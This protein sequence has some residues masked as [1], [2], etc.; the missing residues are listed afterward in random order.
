METE[1]I[2]HSDRAARR[3]GEEEEEEERG[4]EQGTRPRAS[5]RAEVV[6]AL[7]QTHLPLK[8]LRHNGVYRSNVPSAAER[9]YAR[10]RARVA[11][12]EARLSHSPNPPSFLRLS[13]SLLFPFFP[14]VHRYFASC[15][16]GHIHPPPLPVR[17]RS[18]DLRVPSDG[19]LSFCHLPRAAIRPGARNVVRGVTHVRGSCARVLVPINRVRRL[20]FFSSTTS[21]GLR[22]GT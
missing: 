5:D 22:A 13:F 15:F 11:W 9:L 3:N 18:A 1:R 8:Q 4:T 14:V 16:S 21:A 10:A 7:G 20:H 6:D 17:P 2:G 19:A 12:T